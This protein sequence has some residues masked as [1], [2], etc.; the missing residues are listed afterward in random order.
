MTKKY[1][2]CWK[3]STN[4]TKQQEHVEEIIRLVHMSYESNNPDR[5]WKPPKATLS[6]CAFFNIWSHDETGSK[7]RPASDTHQRPEILA[8]HVGLDFRAKPSEQELKRLVPVSSIVSELKL[9]YPPDDIEPLTPNEKARIICLIKDPVLAAA[10]HELHGHF[11]HR[12]QHDDKSFTCMDVI[13]RHFKD[14]EVKCMTTYTALTHVD[15]EVC[16]ELTST[17]KV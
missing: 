8:D 16:A 4:P 7:F 17:V 12:S 15:P 11:T 14:T 1:K 2:L 10:F 6:A 13:A 3:G 9:R 5:L